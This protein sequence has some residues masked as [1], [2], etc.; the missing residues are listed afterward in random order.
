MQAG[1]AE[2]QQET[3]AN[4]AQAT[5]NALLVQ[6]FDTRMR[7]F[8]KECNANLWGSFWKMKLQTLPMGAA[9]AGIFTDA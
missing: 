3:A 4:K 8:R 5:F 1:P 7:K 2:K 6:V 9:I